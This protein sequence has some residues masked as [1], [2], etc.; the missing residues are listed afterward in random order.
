MNDNLFEINAQD[1]VTNDQENCTG[2][3]RLRFAVRNQMQFT[4]TCLDKIIPEEHRVRDV[5]EF[6][7]QLDLSK[8]HDEIKVL[9]GC[10]GPPTV[11]PRILLSLWLYAMLEGIASARQI[12]RLCEEHLAYIWLCGGVTIN[13]HSL[14]SFRSRNLDGFQK[15]L[16]ESIALMWKSGVFQPDEVAQD[17]TRV[18]ANA[19]FSSYRTEKTLHQYLEEAKQCIKNL[20]DNLSKNPSAISHREKSAKKRAINE[21]MERIEKSMAEL[22]QYKEERMVSSKKNRN[23]LTQEDLDKMRA[24]ITDPECRKMKMGD[25]G[26]RLAYNI[27][28][29]TSTSKKI[30]LGVE[31]VNTLDPGTLVPMMKQVEENLQRIGCQM[32][33][34]W[35]A[36]S[37][38][39]NKEDVEKAK[40]NYPETTLYSPPTSTK[41]EIDP[42]EPRKNDT[43]EMAELRSR[44]K[45]NEAKEA[46]KQRGSTAEFSNAVAKNNGMTEFL[47]RGISKVKNMALIYAITQNMMM[48]F[49]SC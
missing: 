41:K 12:A 10:G 6:V 3:K 34:K 47:V 42:L 49:R 31:V 17:G 7:S 26:F 21:R 43:P 9:D 25:G 44:M 14:S 22:A 27:Q 45:S 20:E 37:A 29:A 32:P 35:Y 33:S 15:L 4:I 46:Y 36:D 40:I 23:K 2:K 1:N 8:F 13:Y 28:F 19:G 39:A 5:W 48:Y 38:Y 30:I 11:D 24:S 18:K 16:Q